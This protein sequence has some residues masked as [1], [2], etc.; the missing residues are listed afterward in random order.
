MRAVVQRVLSASVSV[1]GEEVSR[2][3]KGLLVL[4]GVSRG[5]TEADAE[6]IAKK[7]TGLRVFDDGNGVMN[8]SAEDAGAEIM[9]VS[10]FT[11]M[12][13]ARKGRRPS[14]IEAGDPEEARALYE[15]MVE[16]VRNTGLKVETGRYRA[17]MQVSSVN[18]GPVT[19]LLDSK[20][21]F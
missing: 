7:I 5:D 12:G 10:Q 13:D 20:R 1:A 14:Y 2:I 19:I 9:I 16:A 21:L 6:Y 15:R 4:L 3:K 17:D 11:L 18:D 8:L